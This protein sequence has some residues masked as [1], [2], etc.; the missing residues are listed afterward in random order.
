MWGRMKNYPRAEEDVFWVFNHSQY[1][2]LMHGSSWHSWDGKIVW[3]FFNHDDQFWRSL[4]AVTSFLV[5]IV[6]LVLIWRRRRRGKSKDISI[7]RA[8]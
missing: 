6:T 4:I 7:Q 1:F 8:V 5:S 2:D 3:Y